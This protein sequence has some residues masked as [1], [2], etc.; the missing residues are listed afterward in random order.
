MSQTDIA[1][2][3]EAAIRAIGANEQDIAAVGGKEH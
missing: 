2:A 1:R 3:L